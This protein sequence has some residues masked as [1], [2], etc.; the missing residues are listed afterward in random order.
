MI[1]LGACGFQ[2]RGTADTAPETVAQPSPGLAVEQ[3]GQLPAAGF[4]QSQLKQAGAYLCEANENC[5]YRVFLH[6]SGLQ[7]FTLAGV[8]DASVQRKQISLVLDYRVSNGGTTDLI[9]STRLTNSLQVSLDRDNPLSHES[10]LQQA[11][12]R[13]RQRL[14]RQVLLQIK[15]LPD[16]CLAK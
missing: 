14:L 10:Q 11:Q 5:P 9:A 15:H 13:L 2:L 1:Q 4:T 7:S 16:C 12:D 6:W 8:G 3:S